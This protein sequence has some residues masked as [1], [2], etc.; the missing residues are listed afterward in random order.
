[1]PRAEPANPKRGQAARPGRPGDHAQAARRRGGHRQPV[2]RSAPAADGLDAAGGQSVL[3]PRLRQPRLGGYF[4]VGLIDP[5]DDLNLANPPS[6]P[7]LLDYLA[8]GFVEQR[9][10]HEVAA[11]RRS[12]AAGPIS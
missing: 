7:A 8:D 11:P 6:N 5:P 1:M 3:R 10:R 12:P 4:N 2:R 9:L